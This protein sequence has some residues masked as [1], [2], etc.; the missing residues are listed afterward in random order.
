V[1]VWAVA[2]G[3]PIEGVDAHVLLWAHAK[4]HDEDSPEFACLVRR[5]DVWRHEVLLRRA[6][7]CGYQ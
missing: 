4:R 1:L 6:R 7:A 5:P 2:H 3:G